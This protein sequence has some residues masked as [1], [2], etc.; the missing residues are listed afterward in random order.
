MPVWIIPVVWA[1][2]CWLLSL[3]RTPFAAGWFVISVGLAAFGD[4]CVTLAE[5]VHHT[6]PGIVA[7]TFGGCVLPGV[8]AGLVEACA[9][10]GPGTST[11]DIALWRSRP[12][13]RRARVPQW[14]VV[15]KAQAQEHGGETVYVGVATATKVRW[16]GDADPLEDMDA[17]MEL[18]A[19][20]D[21]AVET[22][23]ALKVG[24]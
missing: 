7:A 11:S 2:V 24:Q 10:N 5:G 23:N 13:R 20:A 4:L 6:I 21:Q 17:F 1:A 19:R 18:R 3:R 8:C 9:L 15:T 14:E 12:R 22:L 16:L